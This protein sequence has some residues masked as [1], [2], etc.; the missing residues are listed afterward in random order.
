MAAAGREG[1]PIERRE[2]PPDRTPGQHPPAERVLEVL[3]PARDG[4]VVEAETVGGSDVAPG[5]GDVEQHHQVVGAELVGAHICI[6]ADAL[7][8]NGY[9]E[10]IAAHKYSDRQ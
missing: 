4:R 1:L 6:F 5:A 3:D 7:P 2:L 9:C 10:S 8:R